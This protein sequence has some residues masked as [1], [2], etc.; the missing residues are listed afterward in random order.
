MLVENQTAEMVWNNRSK[1]R[2]IALGYKF[3]NIGDKFTINVKDL[4]PNSHYVVKVKCD[5]C[6]CII[7]KKM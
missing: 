6:G 1:E 4:S 3:T 7:E 2:Y 5:F